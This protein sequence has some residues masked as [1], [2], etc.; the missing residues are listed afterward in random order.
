MDLVGLLLDG[1]QDS[2]LARTSA[3]SI[4]TRIYLPL[5]VKTVEANLASLFATAIHSL[6]AVAAAACEL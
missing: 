5:I 4:D 6:R 1:W 3:R 2:V